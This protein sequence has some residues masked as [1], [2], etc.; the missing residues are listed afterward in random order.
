MLN[1]FCDAE[2][3]VEPGMY[4]VGINAVRESQL[5]KVVE[6]LYDRRM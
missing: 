5:F 4:C 3:M 6:A 1:E 2:H